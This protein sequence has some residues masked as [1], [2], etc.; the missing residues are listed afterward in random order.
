MAAIEDVKDYTDVLCMACKDATCNFQPVALKRRALGEYDVKI[1]M[2]FC[3]ICHTDVHIA[4][5]AMN[6]LI[7]TG[8][9]YNASYRT[10]FYPKFYLSIYLSIYPSISIPFYLDSLTKPPTSLFQDTPVS[11]ATSWL[12][13]SPK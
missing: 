9:C 1:A 10:I 12:V 3:G 7:G 6:N 8:T 11:P 5:G 2:K 4:Q 13:L